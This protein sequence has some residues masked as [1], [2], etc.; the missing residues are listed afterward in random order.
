M[1][2]LGILKLRLESAID[3]HKIAL[4]AF[5]GDKDME[6]MLQLLED[7]YSVISRIIVV[8]TER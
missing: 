5:P 6:H 1:T 3:G 7:C 2:E 8:K 4:Y